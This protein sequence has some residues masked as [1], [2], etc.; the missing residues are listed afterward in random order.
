MRRLLMITLLSWLTMSLTTADT[1]RAQEE[2]EGPGGRFV[3]V[4]TFEIPDQHED[5]VA[6][7]IIERVLPATK[8][9]PNVI[10]SRVL[11]HR[12][13][14]DASRIVFVSEYPSWEAIEADCGTPCEEFYEA[15]P[16]PEEGEEGYEAYRERLE[17]FQKYF[18]EHSDEIYFTPM[19]AAK[20]EGELMGPVVPEPPEE[21]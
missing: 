14:S 7:H 20:V 19:D 5:K 15:N 17:L 8:L 9:N 13:G 18:G 10:N 16:A 4:T 6:Q 11:L 1:I 12:W 2:E 3:T 21:E